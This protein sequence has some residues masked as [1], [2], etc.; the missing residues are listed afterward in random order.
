[1][2]VRR[3]TAD[4]ERLLYT[5]GFNRVCNI[6]VHGNVDDRFWNCGREVSFDMKSIGSSIGDIRSRVRFRLYS[7][8]GIHLFS[9]VNGKIILCGQE[10]NCLTIG[11]VR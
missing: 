7:D 3:R 2:S 4:R 9:S 10:L 6:N 11:A 1:M 5:F 8:V